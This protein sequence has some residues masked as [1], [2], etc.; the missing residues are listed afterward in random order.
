MRVKDPRPRV[1]AVDGVRVADGLAAL[2][3]LVDPGF[4]P[5]KEIVQPAGPATAHDPAFAAECQ[6]KEA[7][8]DRL[9]IDARLDAAG[10]VV[11]TDAFDSGWTARVDGHA[12][13]LL[14]ANVGFRA[15]AVPK[16]RHEVEMLYRPR[17]LWLGLTATATA[18]VL[19]LGTLAPR[20]SST[21]DATKAAA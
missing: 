20:R 17:G 9:R 7:I 16:G 5:E 14:R 18:L 21:R 19:V 12:V 11:V 4:D 1:Y 3:L 8:P 6:L 10:Y 2:E 15:V 13:P